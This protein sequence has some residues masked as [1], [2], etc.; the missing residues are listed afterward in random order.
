MRKLTAGG[1]QAMKNIKDKKESMI[2]YIDKNLSINP[3]LK[4]LGSTNEQL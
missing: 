1:L 2:T 3:Q 4:M